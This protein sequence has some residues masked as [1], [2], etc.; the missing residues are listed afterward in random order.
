MMMPPTPTEDAVRE[1]PPWP[2]LYI[3]DHTRYYSPELVEKCGGRITDTF[4]FDCRTGTHCCEAQLSYEME[5][6]TSDP[7]IVP[8]DDELYDEVR[9]ALAISNAAGQEPVV[10]YRIEGQL[11]ALSQA[12]EVPTSWDYTTLPFVMSLGEP[13]VD[14][15]KEYLEDEDGDV[16]VAHRKYMEDVRERIQGNAPY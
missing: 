5:Y 4:L 9:E 16:R 15:W 3:V 7:G 1:D 11:K 14:K 13:D 2:M 12:D 10:Y 8:E 6:F